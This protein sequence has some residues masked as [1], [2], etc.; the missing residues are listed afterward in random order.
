M[1]SAHAV[2]TAVKRELIHYPGVEQHF[3][4]RGTH[5][6]LTFSLG[7][8]SRF[9]TIP[10]TPSDHRAP[11]NAVRDFR[12]TM[13]ELGAQRLDIL[14]GQTK[15]RRPIIGAVARLSLN[16]DYLAVTIV[17]NG[18]LI[19]RFKAPGDK[20]AGSWTV[21]VR[22]SPDLEA[23]PFIALRKV[24]EKTKGAVHGFFQSNTGG[25]RLSFGRKRI[26]GIPKTVKKVPS[27]N[28]ELH[29]DSGDELLF[30]LPTGILPTSFKRR[31][32]VP[33]EPQVEQPEPE[34]PP[35]AEKPVEQLPATAPEPMNGHADKP[36]VLQFPKQAVS[37]EQALAVLNKAKQ[38]LG[39]NLRFTVT[40]G[41]FLTAVHRIG[42]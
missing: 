28:I 29:Q 2:L 10:K 4:R 35:A 7:G 19:D 38:R 27:V 26:S 39:N 13:R 5:N 37:V 22:S 17:G 12:K 30:K 15:N 40:E 1:P 6:R 20:P 25:W 32:P 3:E 21:E 9:L 16:P 31:A 24:P 42:F 33:V 36:I 23:P 18:P 34:Q 11:E 41:G 8:A 14:P